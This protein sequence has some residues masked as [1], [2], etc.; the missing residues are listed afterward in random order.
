[1]YWYACDE[2]SIKY[3]IVGVIGMSGSLLLKVSIWLLICFGVVNFDWTVNDYTVTLVKRFF[4]KS[5]RAKSS[6]L[7]TQ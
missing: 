5:R 2:N 4:S 6:K 7:T 1:M 3:W